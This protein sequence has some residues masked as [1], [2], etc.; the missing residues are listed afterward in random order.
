VNATSKVLNVLI[1]VNVRVVK[2]V[3][4][5]NVN[6]FSYKILFEQKVEKNKDIDKLILRKYLIKKKISTKNRRKL[7]FFE[8]TN[9]I[10]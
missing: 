3:I 7:S 5:H 10:N 8:K 9:T 2:T 6:L 4:H 1:C